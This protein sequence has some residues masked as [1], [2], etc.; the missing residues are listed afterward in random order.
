VRDEF[1]AVRYGPPGASARLEQEIMREM[2]ELTRTLGGQS[3]HRERRLS[4]SAAVALVLLALAP[5]VLAQAP[6]ERLYADG[7]FR[8]AAESFARRAAAAPDVAAHW[9][10]LG[11]AEYR[12]GS[13]ARARAAWLRAAR[14]APRSAAVRRALRLVPAPDPLSERRSRIVPITPPELALVAIALWLTGWGLLL[15]RRPRVRTRDIALVAAGLACGVAAIG[16]AAYYARP[17][18]VVAAGGPLKLSPHGRAPDVAPIELGATVRPT[19]RVP[20]WVLVQGP[21]G[22]AGWLEASALAVV[23]E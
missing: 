7:A 5:S 8:A 15:R 17:L 21:S 16:T 18:A 20:G 22:R 12:A 19:R 13:D 10:G 6:A 1:L 3:R 9:Y 11:A 23:S 4:R 2:S 14:L